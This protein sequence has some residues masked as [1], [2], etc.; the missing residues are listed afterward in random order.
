MKTLTAITFLALIAAATSAG[1]AMGD[2]VD[3]SNTNAMN[4]EGRAASMLSS[5]NQAPVRADAVDWRQV[6]GATVPEA[7]Y[8]NAGDSVRSDMQSVDIFGRS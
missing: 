4:V 5:S 7:N 3:S 1:A 6:H 8:L 2:K